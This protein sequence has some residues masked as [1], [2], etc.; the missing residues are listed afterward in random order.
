MG[1][2]GDA[3]V[4]CCRVADGE[5]KKTLCGTPNYMAPEIL[6]P[7]GTHSFEV[8][9]WALGVILFVLLVGRPPFESKDVK[10]VYEK[11]KTHQVD[12]ALGSGPSPCETC[13]FLLV[14]SHPR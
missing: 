7:G 11:I 6:E 12:C 3:N 5:R 1:G 14:P 9:V 2:D 4:L 13:P 10:A 8:D